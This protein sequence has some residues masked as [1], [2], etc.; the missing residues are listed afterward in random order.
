MVFICMSSVKHHFLQINARKSWKR[1]TTFK[2]F[3]DQLPD[4]VIYIKRLK[5]FSGQIIPF[6]V[7]KL[8]LLAANIFLVR[9][10]YFFRHKVFSI[11]AA[12]TIFRPLSKNIS[13]RA[14]ACYH[15]FEI[16]FHFMARTVFF[17]G[18]SLFVLVR[19]FFSKTFLPIGI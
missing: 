5:F 19:F 1:R 14:G 15:Q 17:E 4:P 9:Q 10:N 2:S 16:P 7:A 6:W 11:L 13:D 8:I 18:Q 3:G 12:E